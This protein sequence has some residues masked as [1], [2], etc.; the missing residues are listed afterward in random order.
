[1]STTE[2]SKEQKYSEYKYKM[3]SWVRKELKRLYELYGHHAGDI[4]KEQFFHEV[5]I[6]GIGFIKSRYSKRKL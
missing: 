1:M 6:L 3:P 2:S 5:V 4:S